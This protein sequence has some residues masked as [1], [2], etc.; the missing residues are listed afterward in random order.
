MDFHQNQKRPP[1]NIYYPAYNLNRLGKFHISDDPTFKL[2]VRQG[3]GQKKIGQAYDCFFFLQME[4]L[5][6]VPIQSLVRTQVNILHWV[7]LLH[8][9]TNDVRDVYIWDAKPIHLR[10]AFTEGDHYAH[11]K[12]SLSYVANQI[13]DTLYLPKQKTPVINSIYQSI[14]ENPVYFRVSTKISEQKWQ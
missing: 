4:L 8:L 13:D 7:F 1:L 14:F 6:N 11:G 3:F 9:A 10:H 12:G 5:K 2:N